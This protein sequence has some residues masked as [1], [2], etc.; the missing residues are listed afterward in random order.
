MFFVND[1]IW[2]TY[3]CTGCDGSPLR[4]AFPFIREHSFSSQLTFFKWSY[5]KD[6][7]DNVTSSCDRAIIYNI[8]VAGLDEGEA[9]SSVCQP[10]SPGFFSA[11]SLSDHCS[12]C[13]AGFSR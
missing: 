10:C 12:P 1:N 8:N 7:T 5:V 3:E 9:G 13:P 11:D 2:N 4:V 6:H